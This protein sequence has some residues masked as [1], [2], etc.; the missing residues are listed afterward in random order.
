M[1]YRPH[2]TDAQQVFT[3]DEIINLMPKNFIFIARLIKVENALNLIDAFGGTKVF[4]PKR[5]ALN[6][7]SELAQ[8]IGLNRLQMLAD[9]L[10][11]ETI[12]VPMG[13]P[14]TVAMRNRAIREQA[15]TMSKEKLARKFSVT[16][17]TIRSIVNSEEKLNVHEDPNLDLFS[18]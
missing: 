9:Q 13:T 10:G 4:I 7:H 15:P 14:I 5:Q 16:L 18:E 8:V 11:N 17:R 6:V 1:A 3:D 2:I 12:E